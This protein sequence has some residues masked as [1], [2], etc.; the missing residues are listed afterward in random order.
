[1]HQSYPSV[2]VRQTEKVLPRIMDCLLAY[3]IQFALTREEEQ[4]VILWW[5]TGYI[6]IIPKVLEQFQ[7]QFSY[8][9]IFLPE[10]KNTYA[11]RHSVY[12]KN[13]I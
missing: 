13:V 11:Y 8:S 12:Y 5:K 6:Q 4:Q 7:F 9:L 2:A 1:M 10:K 3:I